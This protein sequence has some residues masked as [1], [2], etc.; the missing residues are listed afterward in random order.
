MIVVKMF[1]TTQVKD[2]VNKQTFS[3]GKKF[4]NFFSKWIK[5]RQINNDQ[6]E[7]KKTKWPR[8]IQKNSCIQLQTCQKILSD[9]FFEVFVTFNG[10]YIFLLI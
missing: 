2:R 7:V 3:P 8:Y 9:V 1:L 10:N 4:N 6:H 5:S